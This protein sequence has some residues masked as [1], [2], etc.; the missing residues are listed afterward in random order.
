ME[1]SLGENRVYL[2]TAAA[3]SRYQARTWSE[4]ARTARE[5]AVALRDENTA[6]RHRAASGLIENRMEREEMRA[7]RA[8]T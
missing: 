1:P 5:L 6:V 4:R 2:Q 3:H 7:L 8:A